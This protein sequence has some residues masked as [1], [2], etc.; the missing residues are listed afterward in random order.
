T[1]SWLEDQDFWRFSGIFRDVYLYSKPELHVDDLKVVADLDDTYTNGQLHVQ[2][3]LNDVME[4]SRVAFLL[5]DTNGKQLITEQS[6]LTK[7]HHDLTFD[8]MEPNLWSAEN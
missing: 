4:G 8:V 5:E 2:L 6:D 1:G 3:K 7:Q